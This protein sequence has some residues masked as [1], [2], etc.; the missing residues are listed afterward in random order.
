M[1]SYRKYDGLKARGGKPET[2]FSKPDSTA[3]GQGFGA[4]RHPPNENKESEA[5][6]LPPISSSIGVEYVPPPKVAR[7]D[8]RKRTAYGEVRKQDS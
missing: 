3:R 8:R 5:A 7:V 6:R 2:I 1:V 4:F